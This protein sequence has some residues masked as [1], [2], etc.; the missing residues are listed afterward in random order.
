MKVVE[1]KI[2]CTFFLIALLWFLS[3]GA[4]KADANNDLS[5]QFSYAI[6]VGLVSDYV[7]RGISQ[8]GEEPALQGG[9]DVFGPFDIYAGVWASKVDK[10]FGGLYAW[11]GWEGADGSEEFELDYYIGIKKELDLDFNIDAGFIRYDF[12]DED[13]R[14]DWGEFYFGV[15]FHGL[16]MKV[17]THIAGARM[18]EYYEASYRFD[19][20]D[21]FD[22]TLHAGHFDLERE[23]LRGVDEYS[24]FSVGVGK[25]LHNFG[26]IRLDVTYHDTDDDAK[27]RYPRDVTDNRVV[28]SIQ[29]IFGEFGI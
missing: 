6:N 9:V 4:V 20:L 27:D 2:E 13:G 5:S 7:F 3:I 17:S 28:F 11:A 18:G 19:V 10:P 8:S 22:I 21:Y 24:E 16:K 15:G 1:V 25:T 29:K 26:G 12:N 14:L 23:G